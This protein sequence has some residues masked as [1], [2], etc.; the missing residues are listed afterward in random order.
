MLNQLTATAGFDL[1]LHSVPDQKSR[2]ALLDRDDVMLISIS[3]QFSLLLRQSYFLRQ[4]RSGV[5]TKKNLFHWIVTS[6]KFKLTF[7]TK[8]D[9]ETVANSQLLRSVRVV[10]VYGF[11]R[12]RNLRG[13]CRETLRCLSAT[14]INTCIMVSSEQWRGDTP[15]ASRRSRTVQ[16]S[17]WRP[18]FRESKIPRRP[19]LTG[20]GHGDDGSL[21]LYVYTSVS[22]FSGYL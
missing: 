9:K 11:Y 17:V 8:I 16:M 1:P 18:R 22:L 10:G 15:A 13:R 3:S 6:Q 21:N 7:L 19:W 12:T 2:N 20:Y 14:M 5:P 4:V